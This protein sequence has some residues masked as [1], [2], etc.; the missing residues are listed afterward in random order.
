MAISNLHEK[1]LFFTRQKSRLNT[2]LS[3]IQ[4]TQ[5]SAMQAVQKKQ[6]E[7]NNKLSALYYDDECGYGTEEY[8][9]ILLELQNDHEFEMASLNS[10]ES[11]LE[12]EKESTETQLNEVTQY[13]AS[14][15]KLLQQNI[16]SDFSYGAG[17]GK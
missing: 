16:K 1:L 4:M 3:N 17:G 14:W 15:Q 13:E 12:L 9:E 2:K 7:Y 11:Q 5:L 10:W 6:L 8:G